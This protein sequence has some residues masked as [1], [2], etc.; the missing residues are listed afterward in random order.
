VGVGGK[1]FTTWRTFYPYPLKGDRWT[2]PKAKRTESREKA[3]IRAGTE[4]YP[5]PLKGNRWTTPNPKH[6]RVPRKSGDPGGYR[7]PFLKKV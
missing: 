2:S 5:Y 6:R 7:N 3:E 4:F 1:P